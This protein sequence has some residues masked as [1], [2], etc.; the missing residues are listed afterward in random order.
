[1]STDL[2]AAG[3]SA[4][5]PLPAGAAGGAASDFA[6][7][8]TPA[9][10]AGTVIGTARTI[11]GTA[12]TVVGTASTAVSVARTALGATPLLWMMPAIA[13]QSVLMVLEPAATGLVGPGGMAGLSPLQA[14]AALALIGCGTWLIRGGAHELEWN[15]T[16]VCVDE[17]ARALVATGPY[18]LSR[19]PMYLGAVAVLLG[20]A[21]ALGS[22]LAALVAAGFVFWVDLRH[23]RPEDARLRAQF[24]PAWRAY[25]ARVRRWL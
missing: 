25:A 13:L 22:V 24:G 11:V 2:P 9:G 18:R 19:H 14:L 7:A 6:A 4:R 20:V 1:V 3:A 12:G 8:R 17:T 21:V 16:P 23:A 10:T 5:R 15:A